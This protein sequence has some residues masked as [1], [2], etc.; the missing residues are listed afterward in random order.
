MRMSGIKMFFTVR[1]LSLIGVVLS[2]GWGMHVAADQEIR[3][4]KDTDSD[5]ESRDSLTQ[6]I[7]HSARIG[8]IEANTSIYQTYTN[9][10]LTAK[11]NKFVQISP[12]ERRA[13]LIEVNRRI[14]RDGHFKIEENEQRFGQVVRAEPEAQQDEPL[15]EEFVI[16]S[17]DAAAEE[18]EAVRLREARPTRPPVRR[19]SSGRAYSSQ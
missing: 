13:I 7:V 1:S 10:E 18:E 19:V 4:A 8:E 6:T 17:A 5:A 15:L 9:A 11:L 3:I 14:K 16:L 12:S 2:L